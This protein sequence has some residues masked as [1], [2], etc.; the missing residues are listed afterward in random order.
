M[1]M[2]VVLVC[3]AMI[4]E[5]YHFCYDAVV[6]F[7]QT[8]E[9][10]GVALARQ[11]QGSTSSFQRHGSKRGSSRRSRSL[12][13]RR[14]KKASPSLSPVRTGSI[15]RTGSTRHTSPQRGVESRREGA[16][17]GVSIPQRG[18]TPVDLVTTEVSQ[19]Y[20]GSE[21]TSTFGPRSSP[22]PL[23]HQGG[24]VSE[25]V[26]LPAHNSTPLTPHGNVRSVISADN[27]VSATP[28]VTIASVHGNYQNGPYAPD[29]S[30]CPP[31][32]PLNPASMSMSYA[33]NGSPHVNPL[34]AHAPANSASEQQFNV[35]MATHH[36]YHPLQ[37]RTVP[38]DLPS[39]QGES[40]RL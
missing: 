13:S 9:T 17:L 37:D 19:M 35:A 28:P 22:P 2:G 23:V 15:M 25:N 7:V 12:D 26:G 8:S 6:H 29:I 5:Q 4:Q 16:A 39:S 18:P 32:P 20:G 3:V 27:S 34:P 36:N 14:S 21:D 10:L 38:T 31:N 24:V 1:I 11:R 33:Q 40:T 30:P